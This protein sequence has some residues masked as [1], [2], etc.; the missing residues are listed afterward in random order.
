MKNLFTKEHFLKWLP[1]LIV[2]LASIISC[3]TLLFNGMPHGDDIVFHLSQIEDVYLGFQRGFFGSSTNHVFFGIFAL[4]NCGYYGPF[5][6]HF[7]AVI[8]TIFSFAGANAIGAYK[9]T[10][11]FFTIINAIFAYLL[12]MQISGKNRLISV[13]CTVFY[14]FLPYQMFTAIC[15]QAFAET[16]GLALIPMVFYSLYRIINDKKY[17][18]A[19]Y[20]L[21]I[22]GASIMVLSHPFTALTTAVFAGVFLLINIYKIIVSGRYK[23]VLLN[24]SI[25]CLIICLNVLYYV[26]L[27]VSTKNSGIYRISDD[28]LM[29][30]T[31]DF[32]IGSAKDSI[33][34]SGFLNWQWIL[35]TGYTKEGASLLVFS[36]ILYFVCSCLMLICD[37]FIEKAPKSKYYRYP[38]DLVVL[39]LLPTIFFQR[40]EFYF[41]LAIFYLL[42]ITLSIYND[43]KINRKYSLVDN[44]FKE[45]KIY[46]HPEIYYVSICFVLCCCLVFIGE[47]WKL[48]PPLFYS[49]QFAWRMF[50][51]LFFFLFYL[52]VLLFKKIKLNK[53]TYVATALVASFIFLLTMPTYEK[54]EAYQSNQYIYTNIDEEWL[55]TV[56][57]SGVQNEMVPMVFYQNDYESQYSNS[58][59]ENIKARI[60]ARDGFIYDMENYITP[61]YLKGSG[62]IKITSLNT[63]SV[64]FAVNVTSENALIQ[65]PQFYSDGYYAIHSFY[66]E[67][68]QGTNVDGL[69]A[70]EIPKGEYSI[71]V[72]FRRNNTFLMLQS[73]A[74]VGFASSIVFA[75]AGWR[76]RVIELLPLNHK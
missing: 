66:E 13:I 28:G 22:L 34:D 14:I 32:I 38:V 37:F 53:N 2:I 48:V 24:L 41:G 9:F 44:S 65:L 33:K 31:L 21:L 10:I 72:V 36:M 60:I 18:V 52:V 7:A 42:F 26:V 17:Y 25:T 1:L 55:K 59:Y 15:R 6:H 51:Y 63:P 4:D 69:V 3:Y 62:S 54:R 68:Y 29:W 58:L 64:T 47:F 75:I 27:A 11:V 76:Y 30:S 35:S 61:V 20:F 49:G 74:Y 19:P 5:P 73:F 16:I 70:F 71:E 8:Q 39:F 56:H 23:R 43:R 57:Y 45:D 67:R 40:A 50:G 46:L 12:A